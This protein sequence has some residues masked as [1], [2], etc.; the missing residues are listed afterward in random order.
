MQSFVS[1]EWAVDYFAMSRPKAK[2]WDIFDDAD[3][4]RYL[5]WATMLIKSAFVFDSD[6]EVENDDRI[7]IAVCE[8]ALYL[9]RRPDEYPEALTKGIASASAGPVSATFSKDFIAP[10][11]CE[12]AKLSVAEIGTFIS[13]FGVVKTMLLGGPFSED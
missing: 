12:E 3:R 6:I 11:I 5:N 13:K 1:L 7:K 10:L 4:L 2:E 8:Q 9:M